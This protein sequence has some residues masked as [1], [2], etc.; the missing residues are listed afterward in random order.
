MLKRFSHFFACLLLVLMPLQGFAAANMSV[1]NSMM[2]AQSNAP[3]TANMPCHM[4]NMHK[5]SMH[6][7]S[8]TKTQDSCKHKSA[9]KTNCA[10]LCASLSNMTALNQTTPVMPVL[11]ASQIL[12]A[13]NEIYTSYS[14][15]NL[16]RP[17]NFLS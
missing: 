16:Q 13:Y 9:C 5:N 11:A 4:A 2:Q 17:P 6:M 12:T 15:P 3:K 1:C 7:A 8:M 14:P 10:T